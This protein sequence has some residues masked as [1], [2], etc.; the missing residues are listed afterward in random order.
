M[1]ATVFVCS[2]A[3]PGIFRGTIDTRAPKITLE[4]KIAAAEAIAGLVSEKELRPEYIM[5]SSLDVSTSI[6]VATD[7][8]KVVIEKKLT[9]LKNIDILEKAPFKDLLGIYLVENEI[10]KY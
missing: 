8:A 5:P 3:F 10:E 9:N 7:V 4:M 1:C 2:V 6:R